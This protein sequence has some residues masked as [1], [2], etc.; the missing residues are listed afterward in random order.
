MTKCGRC[1]QEL[2]PRGGLAPRYCPRCGSSLG[3][4]PSLSPPGPLPPLTTPRRVETRSGEVP[5][6][7]IASL[8]FGLIGFIPTCFPAG[9]LAIVLAVS[10]RGKI[11]ASGGH[12]GGRGIATAGLTLGIITSCIWGIVCAGA[13]F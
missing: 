13:A 3:A 4:S 7:A 11:A 9:L 1:S 6:T 8:V 5:G 10:A 12:F 2:T